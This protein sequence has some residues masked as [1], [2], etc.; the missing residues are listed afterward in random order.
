ME[1]RYKYFLEYASCLMAFNSSHGLYFYDDDEN[2]D[3]SKS[4]NMQLQKTRSTVSMCG[5]LRIQIVF[6]VDP[7]AMQFMDKDYKEAYYCYR[8]PE[9]VKNS[10]A[11]VS[12][13][14]TWILCPR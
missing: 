9:Q 4:S 13:G 8:N 14:R 5:E 1:T 11:S 3:E 6:L 10:V 12:N 7:A 2:V